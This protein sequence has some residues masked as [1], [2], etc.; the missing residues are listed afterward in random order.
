MQQMARGTLMKIIDQMVNGLAG[1]IVAIH[2]SEHFCSDTMKIKQILFFPP[3]RM[4]FK[5]MTKERSQ[6]SQWRKY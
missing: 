3:L 2:T 6:G 1:G 5:S 4:G